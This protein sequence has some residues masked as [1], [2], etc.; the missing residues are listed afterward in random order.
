MADWPKDKFK[1]VTMGMI[2]V[3]IINKSGE[4]C[5][6][7]VT[8]TS[9]P[10]VKGVTDN[11]VKTLIEGLNHRKSPGYY[12]VKNILIKLLPRHCIYNLAVPYNSAP[13]LKQFPLSW[14]KSTG[15]HS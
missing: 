11:K 7:S 14:E 9:K 4:E 15:G 3:I 12:G 1:P 5:K 10:I 8:L 2:S 6:L 13:K